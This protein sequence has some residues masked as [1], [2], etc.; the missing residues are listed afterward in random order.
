MP[1]AKGRTGIRYDVRTTIKRQ[2]DGEAGKR[3][4]TRTAAVEDAMK[5]WTL[6][7]EAHRGDARSIEEL[8]RILPPGVLVPGAG[9]GSWGQMP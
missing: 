7:S 1:T 5:L 4:L 9:P 6:V 2:F 8:R 3:G